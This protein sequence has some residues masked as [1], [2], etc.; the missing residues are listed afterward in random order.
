MLDIL[1]VDP[2]FGFFVRKVSAVLVAHKNW[3][4]LYNVPFNNKLA[5]VVM[6]LTTESKGEAKSRRGQGPGAF[7]LFSYLFATSRTYFPAS[8]TVIEISDSSSAAS[9]AG[10]APST[11]NNSAV[12]E[13]VTMHEPTSAKGRGKVRFVFFSFLRLYLCF[14]NLFPCRARLLLVLLLLPLFLPFRSWIMSR[15]LAWIP[16]LLPI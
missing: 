5:P 15:S 8:G 7:F 14:A 13:D 12:D 11:T 2:S 4:S 9:S 6:S 1:K 3:C 10:A 16:V